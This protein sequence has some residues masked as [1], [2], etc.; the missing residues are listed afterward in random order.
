[1][2]IF[3]KILG[4]P[5]SLFNNARRSG[6]AQS[7]RRCRAGVSRQPSAAWATD[8]PAMYDLAKRLRPHLSTAPMLFLR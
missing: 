7:G 4:Q 2:P 8:Y 5:F 6:V 3:G 1:M